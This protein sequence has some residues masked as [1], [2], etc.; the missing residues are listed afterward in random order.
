[1]KY[2][3]Y[4]AILAVIVVGGLLGYNHYKTV[5]SFGATSYNPLKVYGQLQLL[6]TATS[7]GVSGFDISAGCYAI[8]GTCITGGGGGSGTVSSGLAGQLGYY[9]AAGTT[10]VGTST[11]PLYVS[12][13]FATSTTDNATST[14]A[15]SAS[16]GGLTSASRDN[17]LSVQ[18]SRTYTNSGTA[19]SAAGAVNFN[20]TNNTREC[21]EVYTT[22][23][24]SAPSIV[25]IENSLTSQTAIGLKIKTNSTQF[26]GNL[27]ISLQ[28]KVA[29]SI[30]LNEDVWNGGTNQQGGGLF[31]ITSHDNNLTFDARNNTNSGYCRQLDLSPDFSSTTSGTFTIFPC[32]NA[33]GSTTLGTGRFNLNGTTTVSHLANF[34]S[35]VGATEGD[36]LTLLEA[37]GLGISS[38]TPS[39]T[40]TLSVG[41]NPGGV[42]SSTIRMKKIQF[43]GENSAGTVSCM[44]VVGTTPT[45]V[46]GPCVN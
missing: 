38:S 33:G 32:V 46:A 3:K 25:R 41:A 9:N 16:I 39:A 8:N 2:L 43:E 4:I 10:I 31:Q 28:G 36:R 26:A 44:F 15:G 1:M 21:L 7:T 13:I 18:T 35:I 17:V 14:L 11:N 24:V 40:A 5:I 45:V 30:E 29:P 6:N 12:A 23:A 37:G 34:T 27:M 42:A 22:T 20:C 19:Q